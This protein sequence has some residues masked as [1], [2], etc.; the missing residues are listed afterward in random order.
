MPQLAARLARA[1]LLPLW[2]SALSRRYQEL[3]SDKDLAG[4]Y[5]TMSHARDTRGVFGTA[6]IIGQDHTTAFALKMP[7]S[8]A[9]T[10]VLNV[11]FMKSS[12]VACLL[13]P[14]ERMNLEIIK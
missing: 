10:Q 1:A 6:D 9:S 11:M 5:W 12:H 13:D 8:G 14:Y 3:I 2:G 4:L 7:A